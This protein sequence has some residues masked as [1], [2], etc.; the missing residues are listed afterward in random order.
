MTVYFSRMI[1]VLYNI[2]EAQFKRLIV[3]V[4]SDRWRAFLCKTA[5]RNCGESIT[6][7]L[8]SIG[9]GIFKPMLR[10]TFLEKSKNVCEKSVHSLVIDIAIEPVWEG[11][12]KTITDFSWLRSLPFRIQFLLGLCD[13]YWAFISQPCFTSFF[14]K[15]SRSA[16]TEKQEAKNSTRENTQQWTEPDRFS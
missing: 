2:S 16:A 9:K 11:K 8:I 7:N 5:N 6:S 3:K 1:K 13:F 4:P 10:K 14:L 12:W 15:I